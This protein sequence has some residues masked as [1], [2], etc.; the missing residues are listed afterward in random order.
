MIADDVGLDGRA[1]VRNPGCCNR[2]VD[3]SS[4]FASSRVF[5]VDHEKDASM[6]AV[7][8]IAGSISSM[9]ISHRAAIL[10]NTSSAG[11]I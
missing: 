7:V 1:A 4:V 2:L 6:S 10:E 11:T 3:G 9:L 8:I 5:E